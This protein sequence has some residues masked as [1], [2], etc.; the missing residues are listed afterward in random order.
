VAVGEVR[1]ELGEPVPARSKV[2]VDDVETDGQT[3]VVTAVD[4]PLQ[5]LGSAVGL[6]DGVEVHTVVPPAVATRKRSD[7]Q[8]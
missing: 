1:S 5:R 2:V 3:G 6:V 4:E 8:Q 7:W